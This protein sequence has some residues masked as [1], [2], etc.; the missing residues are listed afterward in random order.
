MTCG[1][2]S[3]VHPEGHRFASTIHT[4]VCI[5][6]GAETPFLEPNTTECVIHTLMTP[7]SRNARFRELLEKLIGMS[8]GPHRKDPIWPFLAK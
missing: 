5:R 3:C 7:Y 8:T 4:H 2:D 1:F 6:C